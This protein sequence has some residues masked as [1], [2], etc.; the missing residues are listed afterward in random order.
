MTEPTIMETLLGPTLLTQVKAPAKKTNDLLKDKELVALYFSAAWCPPCKAFSPLL[1]EFY[2]ACIK[3]DAKLEIVYVSSDSSIPEF[4]GY[5]AKMP[6]LAIPSAQGSAA[7]KNNLA[8]TLKIT[9]IPTLV[10]ID[11]K[12]GEFISGTA[13]G[14]VTSVGNDASKRKELIESWKTKERVPLSEANLGGEQS[15]LMQIIMFFARNPFYIFGLL[16][17]FKWLSR[18]MYPQIPSGDV[19]PPVMEEPPLED[20]EF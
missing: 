13:R 10:I 8:Q 7:I 20:S 18:Q 12:T 3:D 1:A 5:Y 14:D 11:A 6:W 2:K 4:E 17:M 19:A 16:Y 15:F 9:G